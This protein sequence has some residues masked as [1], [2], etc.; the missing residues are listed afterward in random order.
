MHIASWSEPIE[1]K[2][3]FKCLSPPPHFRLVLAGPDQALDS[4]GRMT[5]TFQR[6]G[7]AQLGCLT[8]ICRLLLVRVTAI[9]IR[10]VCWRNPLLCTARSGVSISRVDPNVG[11]GGAE[12]GG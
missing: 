2:P 8:L 3:C 5:F 4:P 12:G 9:G 1:T 6:P 11:L 10:G 7:Q